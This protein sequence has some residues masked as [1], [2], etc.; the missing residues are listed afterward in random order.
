MNVALGLSSARQIPFPLL[1][2]FILSGRIGMAAQQLSPATFQSAII[3]GAIPVP[4]WQPVMRPALQPDRAPFARVLAGTV[5]GGVVGAAV[6]GL[7]GAAIG[8]L[9]GEQDGLVSAS[10]AL[11]VIGLATLY[12]V[13]AAIGARLAA[14]VDGARPKLW[15][16]VVVSVLSG[17]AG[18]IIW[19]RV[20]EALERPE[21]MRSWYI[22]AGVGVTTH[23]VLTSLVAQRAPPVL[24]QRPDPA[25][26][27]GS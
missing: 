16:L 17:V 25:P 18:G 8:S 19:N 23:W 22:G 14:T 12:P 27:P 7:G 13:G 21:T 1:I 6:G 20:G 4:P 9:E 2:L 3:P 5:L 24:G 10:E 11:G 26:R 15:P